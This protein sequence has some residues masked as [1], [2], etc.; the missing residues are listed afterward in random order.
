MLVTAISTTD[1]L[2]HMSVVN[3]NVCVCVCMAVPH[4]AAYYG[5]AFHFFYFSE[6]PVPNSGLTNFLFIQIEGIKV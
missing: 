2:V 6:N 4:P 1:V 3:V 5:K